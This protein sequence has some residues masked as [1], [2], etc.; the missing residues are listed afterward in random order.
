MDDSIDATFVRGFAADERFV[1]W[2]ATYSGLA[3]GAIWMMAKSA[4][5]KGGRRGMGLALPDGSGLKQRA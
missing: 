3:G 4:V 1:Y 5:T 2:T